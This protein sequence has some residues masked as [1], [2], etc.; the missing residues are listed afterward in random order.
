M[1]RSGGVVRLP[2]GGK[3]EREILRHLNGH[4]V[5][6]H[7][8]GDDTA[9]AETDEEGQAAFDL[10]ED[11]SHV[12]PHSISGSNGGWGLTPQPGLP[13]FSHR[14]EAKTGMVTDAGGAAATPEQPAGPGLPAAGHFS[15]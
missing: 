2:C 8:R 12:E 3:L 10:V 14:G 11:R 13:V 6:P 5:E 4:L 15:G 7:A 1:L 9:E